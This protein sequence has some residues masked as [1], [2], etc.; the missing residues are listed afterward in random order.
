MCAHCETRLA[1]HFLAPDAPDDPCCDV[2]YP[3][4]WTHCD[5]CG[6][7]VRKDDIRELCCDQGNRDQPPVYEDRCIH[8]A[9]D[10]REERDW[11]RVRD[12]LE[13]R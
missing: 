13:D 10:T 8:C 2:C 12:E 6:A 4:R 9:P 1:T 7:E 3:T 5:H 11:D